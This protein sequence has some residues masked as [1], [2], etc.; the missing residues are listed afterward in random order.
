MITGIVAGTAHG[1]VFGIGSSNGEIVWSRVFGLGWAGE[2]GGRV[3]PVKLFV[4]KTDCGHCHS[5][6]SE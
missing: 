6:T 5:K 1:K 4:I 2:I 3:V